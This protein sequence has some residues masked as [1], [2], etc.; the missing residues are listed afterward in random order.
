MRLRRRSELLACE[1]GREEG[2]RVSG[3]RESV[4]PSRPL[5]IAILYHNDTNN[6]I[7]LLPLIPYSSY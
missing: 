2:V 3:Y 1:G 4:E 7:D 5:N 6:P